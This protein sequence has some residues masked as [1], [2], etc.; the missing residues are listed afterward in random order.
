MDN[1]ETLKRIRTDLIHAK[2]SI[3]ELP[4][5]AEEST[6]KCLYKEHQL[7]KVT[8]ILNNKDNKIRSLSE[9]NMR[10]HNTVKQKSD[11]IQHIIDKRPTV[12]MGGILKK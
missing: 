9:R 11:L 6:K 2:S 4:D 3:Q 10:L 7:I 1:N 8:E 5:R 12:P